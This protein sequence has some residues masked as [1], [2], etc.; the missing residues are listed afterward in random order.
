MRGVFV[1]AWW[2]VCEQ[3][4]ADMRQQRDDRALAEARA[5]A[6]EYE[7]DHGE[8]DGEDVAAAAAHA[9]VRPI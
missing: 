5:A 1:C 4:A 8:A 9:Q 3:V 6:E 7:R 2:Q